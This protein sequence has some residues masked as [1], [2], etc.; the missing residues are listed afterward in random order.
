MF[1]VIE[2]VLN[3]N[4]L[5]EMTLCQIHVS[6]RRTISTSLIRHLF[7]FGSFVLL[8]GYNLVY[9]NIFEKLRS[10]LDNFVGIVD[11]MFQKPIP[12]PKCHM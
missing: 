12:K 5:L 11:C 6:L 10:P 8:F 3:L 2:Y 4:L 1:L 9:P 7:L